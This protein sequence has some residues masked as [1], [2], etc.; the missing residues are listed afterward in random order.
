MATSTAAF[1]GL[2]EFVDAM[3]ERGLDPEDA[4]MDL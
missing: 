3:G 1:P 4:M 2:Q